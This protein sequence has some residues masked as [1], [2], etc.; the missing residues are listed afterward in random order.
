MAGPRGGVAAGAP[1]EDPGREGKRQVPAPATDRPN[2]AAAAAAGR[3]E[4][5]GWVNAGEA[6]RRGGRSGSALP[7]TTKRSGSLSVSRTA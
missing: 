4:G 2:N 5:H 7:H 6:E 1:G 3:A